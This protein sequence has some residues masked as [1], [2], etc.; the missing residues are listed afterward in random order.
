MSAEPIQEPPR[1]GSGERNGE[2]PP[3]AKVEASEQKDQVIRKP[4]TALEVRT[5]TYK[6]PPL[7][8][9]DDFDCDQQK[10][11]EG[12]YG[13]V[14]KACDKKTKEIVALKQIPFTQG[15]QGV[16]LPTVGWNIDLPHRFSLHVHEPLEDFTD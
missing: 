1:M 9:V 5:L 7:R 16:R 12:T 2:A 15:D 4:T 13:K 14:F 10:I 3:A 8:T 6:R 11:G